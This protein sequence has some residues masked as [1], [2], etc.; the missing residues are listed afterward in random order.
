MLR[1]NNAI[2]I[3][4]GMERV[5]YLHPWDQDKVVKISNNSAR[6]NEQNQCEFKMYTYLTRH[7]GHLD[8]ISRC[9]GFSETN[10]G[11]GLVCQCIR[12]YNGQISRTLLETLVNPTKDSPQDLRQIVDTFCNRIVEDN[13]QLFDMNPKNIV[14]RMEQPGQYRAVSIDLKGRYANKEFIPISTFIPFFSRKKLQRRAE[15]L[16]KMIDDIRDKR[17]Q[18]P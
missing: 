15:R 14:L 12:D 10:L 17:K 16:L 11:P 2:K 7:H 13:I 3:G 8:C 5:C 18:F 4:A 6:G 9:Y 1:L